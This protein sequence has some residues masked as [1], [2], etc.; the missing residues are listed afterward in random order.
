MQQCSKIYS[1]GCAECRNA[2][3]YPAPGQLLLMFEQEQRISNVSASTWQPQ[4][5]LSTAALTLRFV[6]KS[7]FSW[8]HRG[9]VAMLLHC[10]I[11]RTLA[12]CA[13]FSRLGRSRFRRSRS[14]CLRF[15]QK[16]RCC[17][18]VATLPTGVGALQTCKRVVTLP[19]GVS[20]IRTCKRLASLPTGVGVVRTCKRV[21]AGRSHLS[22]PGATC[23]GSATGAV[24]GQAGRS[25][26]TAP[27]GPAT[28]PFGTS[29]GATAMRTS[30]IIIWSTNSVL[31]WPA[32]SARP[33]LIGR[34]RR[35]ISV[36]RLLFLLQQKRAGSGENSSQ[37]PLSCGKLGT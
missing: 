13:A 24:T 15:R 16:T 30:S 14:G 6:T 2:P 29:D 31:E 27:P 1:S 18:R 20:A 25:S 9:E 33:P 8:I 28:A 10:R 3:K 36:C 21:E 32:A 23:P 19:T 11:L 35:M 22:G 5:T 26:A 34:R 7:Y 4:S 37:A 12:T 17:K